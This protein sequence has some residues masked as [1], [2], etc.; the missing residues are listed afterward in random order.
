VII[1]AGGRDCV[2]KKSLGRQWSVKKTG[3][4]SMEMKM[5]GWYM[6]A[7]FCQQKG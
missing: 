2:R 3:V 6:I 7:T 5:L 4:F 1:E